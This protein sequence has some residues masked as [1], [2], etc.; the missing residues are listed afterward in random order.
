MDEI[1]FHVVHEGSAVG[2]SLEWPAY[3]VLDV[4]GL[5]F[6]MGLWDLP[7]LFQTNAIHLWITILT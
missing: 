4:T 1:G 5:E 2:L 7:N 3:S 6:R